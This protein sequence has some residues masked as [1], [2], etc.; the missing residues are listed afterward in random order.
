MNL[1]PP[2]GFPN[3]PN[4]KINFEEFL[5]KS[6]EGFSQKSQLSQA[7][8]MHPAVSQCLSGILDDAPTLSSSS[9]FDASTLDVS[10]NLSALPSL[11]RTK[12]GSKRVQQIIAKS[13]P[14][15]IDKIIQALL[16]DVAELMCD[17]YGNYMC[18]TLFQSCSSAHRVVLLQAMENKL[19]KISQDG[20]GTHSL[21]TLISLANLP[22]EEAVYKSAFTGHIYRLSTH[23]NATHV[24]Q[25]LLVTFK[26]SHF[27]I[28][29]IM[30]RVKELAMDKLGLC[31][32]KKCVNDPQVFTELTSDPMMLMQDPYGNY[33][34]QHLI[35]T[36][37]EECSFQ[38]INAMKGRCAQLSIQKYS[39]NVMEK[40][41]KEE[42]MRHA[43]VNEF[44]QEEKLPLLLNCPYGCYVLRTS[45]LESEPL[46]RNKL[47][48]AI[49]EVIPQLHQKKLKARWDEILNSLS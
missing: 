34:M 16:T 15:E 21:Q 9:E 26:N 19:V 10:G 23:A 2:P 32:I 8:I 40:C 30:G 41:M 45:A 42:K 18:Q 4:R 25:R 28:R 6:W 24:I 39:S 29:E 14:E 12:N 27:I 1:E 3:K 7:E 38:M 44:I 35:D 17:V 49:M 20:R 43:I 11:C 48:T 5:A 36:W 46:L 37:R 33:A 22:Q 13:R 31:V 47:R